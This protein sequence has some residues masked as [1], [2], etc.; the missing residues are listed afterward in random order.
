MKRTMVALAK[1]PFKVLG[2]TRTATKSEVKTRYRELAMQYHPDS[3]HGDAA[4]ME[5]INRAYN[6]LI[7]EGAFE[8]LHLSEQPSPA[9]PSKHPAPFSET[10][11]DPLD[12]ATVGA[13]DIDSERVNAEG[14]FMYQ[15]RDSGQWVTLDKPLVRGNQP[16]YRS[17]GN[18]PTLTEDLRS[19]VTEKE[20]HMNSKSYVDRVIDRFADGEN[21]PTRNRVGLLLALCLLFL[22]IRS[23]YMNSNSYLKHVIFRMKHYIK[24]DDD[25]A[26]LDALYFENKEAVDTIVAAAALVVLTAASKKELSDPL[27]VGDGEQ[28]Y[29]HSRPHMKHFE[30]H[31]NN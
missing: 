31:S 20:K 19:H 1:D 11:S 2:L 18:S 22:T 28:Y 15:N 4:K 21:L 29:R 14:K 6:L 17:F 23:T 24:V 9:R 5:Q 27:I 26:K 16:R 25:L 8:R 10:S 12:C 3:S 13:L 30:V 7:K